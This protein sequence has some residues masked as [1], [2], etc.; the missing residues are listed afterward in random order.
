M[1]GTGGRASREVTEIEAE[2]RRVLRTAVAFEKRI[3]DRWRQ[4]CREKNARIAELEATVARLRERL[5][6]DARNRGGEDV[7]RK[8]RE[9]KLLA[10]MV[11]DL[12]VADM[13]E[14]EMARLTEEIGGLSDGELDATLAER[15]GLDGP[16]E[17]ALEEA[18]R[19]V[20]EPERLSDDGF[21]GAPDMSHEARPEER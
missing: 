4:R 18:L 2:Y 17:A 3:R 19:G 12:G 14:R 16:D 5:E 10:L 21:T 20:Q 9:R 11:A 7:D 15:L 1:N 6:Q 8:T 13:Q